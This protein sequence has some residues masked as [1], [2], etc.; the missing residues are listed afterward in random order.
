MF[1]IVLEFSLISKKDITEVPASVMTLCIV[2]G[3]AGHVS[4]D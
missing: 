3:G 1:S 4:D 2:V